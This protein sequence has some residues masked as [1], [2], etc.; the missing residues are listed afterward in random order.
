MFWI[1]DNKRTNIFDK[2]VNFE[3]FAYFHNNAMQNFAM[4][5]LGDLSCN[6]STMVKKYSKYFILRNLVSFTFYAFI[7]WAKSVK[8]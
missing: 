1:D 5:S 4:S 3:T 2:I 7:L 6:K 8:C